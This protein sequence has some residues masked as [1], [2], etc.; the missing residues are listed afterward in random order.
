MADRIAIMNQ[1]RVEQIGTPQEIYDRPRTMFV[2]DFIGAPPMSFLNVRTALRQGDRVI[3]IDG[4]RLEIPELFEDRAEGK[5]ALGVRPENVSF[6]DSS[7]LRGRVRFGAS[8]DFVT[9][10]LPELL[11]DFVRAHPLVDL[12][13]T[14][15]L[16][17]TLYQMV[18]KKLSRRATAPSS[19]NSAPNR[20]SFCV[21]SVS[22]T[23]SSSL[24]FSNVGR[25]MSRDVAPRFKS[26]RR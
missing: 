17:A 3:W 9:S 16:S 8:E 23:S 2:A 13:L 26:S 22:S 21:G 15:D 6:A 1:G 11:A 18:D 12:A 10:R 7:Q 5:F 19:R 25:V 14:V 4:A 20:K 24:F